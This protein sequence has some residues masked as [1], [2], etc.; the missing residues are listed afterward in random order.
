MT[1]RYKWLDGARGIAL[2]A[3]A[4]YHFTWDLAL[5]G[6]IDPATPFELSWRLFAR[7]IAGGFLVLVGVG[8]VIAH[9]RGIRWRAFG[10]RLA[11]ILLA[12]GVITLG[13]YVA[14]PDA[15]IFFGILHMIAAGSVA[16]LP[17][18]RAPLW[19]VAAA[20]IAVAAIGLTFASP[21]FDTPWL[22]WTGLNATPVRSNDLVPFFP[23]FAAVLVGVLAARLAG[24]ERPAGVSAP[25]ASNVAFGNHPRWPSLL[26][27]L[28]R[29][30]LV[31]YIVHQP[32]L[33]GAL[34]L[35]LRLGVV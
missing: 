15:F 34:W 19:V 20:A 5:F 25:D 24:L 13:T 1:G 23:A 10:R 29:H 28:G 31:V 30:S 27:F 22:W 33:I 4:I 18:L 3:M 12:A 8:L 32:I 11:T 14:T 2:V 17:F 6:L 35:A 26:R 21:A 16:A 9:G 7:A